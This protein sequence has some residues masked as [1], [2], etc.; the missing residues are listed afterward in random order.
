[1]Q[2]G[3]M[4]AQCQAWQFIENKSMM[5][6]LS[7]LHRAPSLKKLSN[8][9]RRSPRLGPQ[10]WRPVILAF[11]AG[12]LKPGLTGKLH[13]QGAEPTLKILRAVGG[14]A[15]GVHLKQ[16]GLDSSLY[17]RHFCSLLLGMGGFPWSS[18]LSQCATSK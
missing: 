14:L 1:M 13:K 12:W 11:Q 8:S 10:R 18:Q 2:H 17:S 15:S 6:A 16:P 4:V 3:W 7:L 5:M 9:A